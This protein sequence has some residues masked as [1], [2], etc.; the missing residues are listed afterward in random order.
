M[1]LPIVSIIIPCYNNGY[2]LTKMLDC[3]LRQ[4]FHKWEVII[5]DDGSADDTPALIENYVCKDARIKFFRRDRQPKGSVVCR[6]I[7]F[8]KSSGKYIIHF[9]ADDLISDTCFE[10]RVRFMEEHPDIDY[11]SFCA[12]TFTDENNLPRYDSKVATYGV[13]IKTGDLLE[14]FLTTNYSFSVWNNIYRREAIKDHPWDEAVKIQT[15]FSYIVPG[16]LRGMRH[17]FAGYTE[18]DYYYRYFIDKKNSNNMCSNF[19]TPEKCRSTLYLFENVFDWLDQRGDKEIRKRQFLRFIVLQFER[20]IKEG[21]RNDTDEYVIFLSKHYSETIVGRLTRIKEHCYR[22]NNQT[23][24]NAYLNLML[25]YYFHYK[26]YM[27]Q[28]VHVV[29][30]M[31]LHR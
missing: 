10:H 6:N 31:F 8:E 17:A 29:A 23:K 12:K 2:Y 18:V 24:K 9:D 14:D 16:I 22:I 20:L 13:S 25:Y 21:S 15:D 11:A 27:I 5:V 3:C 1:E 19:V 26:I 28:F 30:K 7:G 4:T